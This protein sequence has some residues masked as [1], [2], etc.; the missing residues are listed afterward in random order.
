[1]SFLTNEVVAAVTGAAVGAWITYLFAIKLA[2]RQFR[3]LIE[4]SKLDAQRI[5]AKE[6]RA[7]F[8]PELSAVESTAE[9]GVNLDIYLLNAYKAKHRVAITTFGHFVPASDR[10]RFKA[11]CQQYHSG[12][13]FEG[14]SE[15]EAL[16]FE[17]Q[18]GHPP[19]PSGMT[20]RALAV[21][22]IHALLSFASLE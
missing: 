9:L 4:V 15:E 12:Y 21:A 5:A 16:F 10:E 8:D 11:A 7:A 6:F 13:Q 17:Y 1:M 20:R 2:D 14:T 22:R 3:H 19:H 18:P